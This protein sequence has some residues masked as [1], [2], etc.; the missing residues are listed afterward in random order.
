MADT[1]SPRS[2][3][4]VGGARDAALARFL[5]AA[6]GA[7]ACEIT[8]LAPLAGGAIQEN[9]GLDA[10][11]MGGTLDGAQHLVLR[12]AGETGVPSSLNRL[13]EYTVLRAAF[14]AGVTVP[15]PLIACADPSVFG[16][17]FF[18]MRRAAGTAAAHRITRD[19]SL[20][21]V[22]SDI[23]ERLGRELARIHTIRPPRP[24]LA[25]LP[26]YAESGPSRQIAGFR[27]YLDAHPNPRPV[28]EWGIRWL[29]THCPPPVEPV[30]CHHD[31]RTGNYLLDGARLTGILDW[32]FAGW[33][34]PH[35]DIGW[36][37]SKG[38][39][40]ARLDREAGGI[41]DRAPF[42]RGYE[43]ASGRLI[44]PV[45]VFFWE[46]L[47]SV[48]WAVIALQQSDRHILAG[49]RSLDLALTG[50]RATEC[51]LAILILLDPGGEPKVHLAEARS[52]SLAKASAEAT[53]DLPPG[54]ALLALA[55]NVLINDLLP[56]LPV[57]HQLEARLIANCM[58]IAER[59]ARQA[60]F[61]AEQI[62][63][64]LGSFYPSV[65][66]RRPPAQIS[67]ADEAEVVDQSLLRHFA[68]ELRIG[69]FENSPER[70]AEVRTILWHWTIAKLRLSNPRFLA[71]NG[72]S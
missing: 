39:R 62:E 44:D 22:L 54:P 57:E 9:W 16:K 23:A 48:R 25:F 68:H 56:L 4:P 46:V 27:A 30:L 26:P 41:A 53:R 10:R 51:E 58:A 38:W 49:E 6:S 7:Q 66:T 70:E 52:T 29:E 36:F 59:E 71:A 34:D 18:V 33:G 42:Y 13:Q 2:E 31:F 14:D 3:P 40:F 72:L 28:L 1:A 24:D 32:E 11:F 47:A 43:S 61:G 63:R 45:R 67:R 12:A 8:G 20:E 35:E 15:E 69:G 19:P 5:T 55:R 37:C 17:P 50:R 60:A 64:E 65:L 21:S